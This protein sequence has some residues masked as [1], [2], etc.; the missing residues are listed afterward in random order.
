[1]EAITKMWVS[2]KSQPANKKLFQ[3]GWS[4]VANCSVDRIVIAV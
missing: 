4:E 1:M 3:A 2:I